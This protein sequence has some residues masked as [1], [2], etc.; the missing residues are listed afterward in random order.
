MKK[1]LFLALI[2]LSMFMVSCGE[3][4]HEYNLSDFKCTENVICNKCGFVSEIH[5]DHNFTNATCVEPSKCKYCGEK[6]SSALGHKFG[7]YIYNNDGTCT[8]NGTE[9]AQCIRCGTLKTEQASYGKKEHVLVNGVCQNCDYVD[10][11]KIIKPKSIELSQGRYVLDEGQSKMID[12]TITPANAYC[13]KIIWVSSDPSIVNVS[14]TGYIKAL[15]KGNAVITVTID[16]N[17]KA[18][19]TVVVNSETTVNFYV[20]EKL[21][22]SVQTIYNELPFDKIPNKVIHCYKWYTDKKYKN[23]IIIEETT[24][25]KDKGK[26]MDLY[27]IAL[28]DEEILKK[29]IAANPYVIFT[30]TEITYYLILENDK[31]AIKGSKRYGNDTFGYSVRMYLCQEGLIEYVYVPSVTD[32]AKYDDRKLSLFYKFTYVDLASGEYSTSYVATVGGPSLVSTTTIK[33]YVKKLLDLS[34]LQTKLLLKNL[35]AN[36]YKEI[37]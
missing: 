5:G 9:T 8:R 1:G 37:D 12:Y 34:F 4:E 17:V 24:S 19:C 23:E 10:Y 11:T 31:L 25:F 26:T 6:G 30:S 36:S 29:Y 27:G 16:D 21:I 18:Q 22:E 13:K 32:M 14:S 28:T 35:K 7:E 3:C 2:L 33:R 20:G 15:K